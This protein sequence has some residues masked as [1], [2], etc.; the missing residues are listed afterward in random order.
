MIN[1]HIIEGAKALIGEIAD[2]SEEERDN[3]ST[4]EMWIKNCKFYSSALLRTK[5]E[6]VKQRE[7]APKASVRKVLTAELVYVGGLQKVIGDLRETLLDR[8]EKIPD[9]EGEVPD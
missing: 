4:L 8:Y 6:Y 7:T 1:R 9:K 2:S 5:G 3:L